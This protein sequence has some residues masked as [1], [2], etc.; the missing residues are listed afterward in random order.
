MA[1]YNFYSRNDSN[2]EPISSVI[3]SGRL[4]AAKHFSKG[5]DMELKS[6]LSIFSVSK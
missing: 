5:K 6:F 2:K 4:E 1:K 3:A